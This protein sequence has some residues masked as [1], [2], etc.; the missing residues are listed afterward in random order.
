[1]QT[2]KLD[3][4]GAWT[5]Q[6]GRAVMVEGRDKLLQDV[7]EILATEFSGLPELIGETVTDQVAFAG[8]AA[9]ELRGALEELRGLHATHRPDKRSAEESLG[10]VTTVQ[11]M[12]GFIAF[13]PVS[14]TRYIV[15]IRLSSRADVEEQ[16][17]T[18]TY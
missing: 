12:P 11:I 17:V 15:N 6:G 1:M 8:T 5:F 3:P 13:K 7:G 10:R 2:I 9:L 16:T 18:R 14:R 4:H